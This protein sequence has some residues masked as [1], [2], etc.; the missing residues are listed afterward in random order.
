MANYTNTSNVSQFIDRTLTANETASLNGFIL[1]AVDAWIDRLLQS[2]FDTVSAT[3]RYY[4]G[5]G[6]TV[7]IDPVQLVTEV[8]TIDNDGNDDYIYT[9][10]TDYV[11]EPAN[12]T[13]KREIVYRGRYGKYPY[14]ERRVAVTGKFTEYDF[15]ANAIPSDIVLVA[16]RLASGVIGAGTLAG[17]GNIESEELEGHKIKYSVQTSSISAIAENDP[18][19]AGIL[20]ARRE[21]YI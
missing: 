21:I 12:E 4:D 19:L 20:D 18:I 2:H 17:D 6:H 5:G 8:K 13:I 3:T 1:N 7:D 10:N 14:G 16:T 15:T 9:E 11:L